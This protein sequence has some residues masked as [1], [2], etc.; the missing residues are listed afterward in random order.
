MIIDQIREKAQQYF[1]EVQAIRHHLHAHPELSFQEHETAA[2]VSEQLS[3][4]GIKH[5]KGIAG[6]GIVGLIEG[7]PGGR[8]IALRADMDALPIQEGND[9]SYRSQNNGVMHACG[10]DVHTSCLLGAAHILND[11]REH[12]EGTIKLLFQPGE[13]KNPGG[14]SIMIKDGAL[15]NPKPEAIFAL[16]VY[17]HLPSGTAGFRAGQYMASADEIYITIEGKGGHAALPHQTVDPIAIAALVIT[18]L[19]QVISRKGNPLIPSVLTFGKI[20]GGFATNVIPDK[21]EILGTFRTMNEKWR[22]EAH[23]WI[24]EFTEQT[25]AAYGAKV[26]VEIPPGYPSLSNDPA[27]TAQA[28]GWAKAYLGENNVHDLDMRMAGEDFSFYTQH[29]PGCFFRIGT[30]KDGKQFTAPVHNAR[31]DI[32][33][34][35]LKVGMG[36]MAWCGLNGAKTPNP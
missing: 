14:A 28:E 16:H 6:T 20:Q 22:Y 24:K 23:K 17:P 3:A 18:G 21:V 27:L 25:C 5:E 31:F 30:S 19:Q 33:E 1:P 35:S 12:F 13:E 2:F 15:E 11:L 4:W 26:T 8:C 32:D 9:V 7:K 29:M 34:D 10:H 36:M